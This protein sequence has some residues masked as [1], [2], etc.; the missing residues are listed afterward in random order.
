MQ[1]NLKAIDPDGI[2]SLDDD[3]GINDLFV[4]LEAQYQ[5]INSFGST[6]LDLSGPVFSIGFLFEF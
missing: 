5:F 4:T 3:F 6:G 1:I 2:K